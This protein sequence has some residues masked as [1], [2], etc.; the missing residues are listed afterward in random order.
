MAETGRDE[1]WRGCQVPYMPLAVAAAAAFHQAH[2]ST[3]AIVSR[4]DYEDA[5]NIAAA[6]LSRLLT[7][8]RL[9]DAREGRVPVKIDLATQRF[10]RG[11]TRLR[12]PQGEGI[13]EL[14]VETAAFV[15]A[16]ALVRGAGLPFCFASPLAEQP[17][18]L[19]TPANQPAK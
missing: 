19:P 17:E 3:R 4:D 14:S 9:R 11:A 18:R 8:Y 16:L 10:A 13:G 2:G 5:L 7:I 12:G 1:L 6:A 15:R